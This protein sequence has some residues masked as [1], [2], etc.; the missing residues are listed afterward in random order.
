MVTPFS[1]RS[2]LT[3]ATVAASIVLPPSPAVADDTGIYVGANVGRVLSTY[4]HADLDSGITAAFGAGQ[5]G[6]TLGPSS[7]EKDR[8][9][10]SADVGYMFSHNLGIEA[11]YL[12][13]GSVRYSAFGS[14]TSPQ[15]AAVT[16]NVETKS[17]GPALAMVGVLPM[18]NI[19]ELHARAGVYQ[20][21]TVS[22][23]G[24]AVD[25]NTSGDRLSKTSTSLMA[26]FGAALTVSSHYMVRL[27]YL[28]L[29]DLKEK[30]FDKSFNVDLVTVG[31]AYVF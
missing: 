26:G 2:L 29:Q 18:S 28:R 9:M 8:F 11:S 27:D 24:I 17:Q 31:I 23:Y 6:F 14:E 15:V 21:K 10:W 30:A 22:T 3:A 19:W 16:A 4:R 1:M 20:G 13:L 25:V 12:H 5:G 7:V